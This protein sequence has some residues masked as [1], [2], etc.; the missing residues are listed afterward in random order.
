MPRSMSDGEQLGV[1]SSKP[2]G[3]MTPMIRVSPPSTP[4]R[5]LLRK[6]DEQIRNRDSDT[7]PEHSDAAQAYEWDEYNVS[8]QTV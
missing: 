1:V 3:M 6:L 2:E 5:R 7:A 4:V 8:V